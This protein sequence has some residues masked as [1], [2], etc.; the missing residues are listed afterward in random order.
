MMRVWLLSSLIRRTAA[1]VAGGASAVTLSEWRSAFHR[2]KHQAGGKKECCQKGHQL[3]M[4]S[5]LKY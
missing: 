5:K 3:V 4:N 1:A 2:R